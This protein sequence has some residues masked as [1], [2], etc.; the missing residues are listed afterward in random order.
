MT[1]PRPTRFARVAALLLLASP[2]PGA[3]TDTIQFGSATT[4]DTTISAAECGSVSV[5]VPMTWTIRTDGTT[6]SSGGTYEIWAS[7]TAPSASSG[8]SAPLYCP[9][10][11]STSSG[12]TTGEV[13]TLNATTETVASQDELLRAMVLAA[14]YDC[15][16]SSDT[17]IVYVC[18]HWKDSSGN[19]HGSATGQLEI[20]VLAPPAPA[21][22]SVTPGET[23]LYAGWSAGTGSGAPV[24]Y[25]RIHAVPEGASDGPYSGEITGT[26]GT[27]SGLETGKAYQVTVIAYSNPGENPSA[28]SNAVLGTPVPVTDFWEA[29]QAQAGREGGGCASGENGE[30]LALAGVVLA[31][32]VRRRRS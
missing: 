2:I 5:T 26:S 21:L 16:A 6:F 15:S 32:L 12:I 19:R 23:R 14:G 7:N 29:Y 8:T 22:S 28:E 4:A 3:A 11:D 27:I 24:S 31:L 25:Y 17:Q 13:D 20:Q 1:I 10:A 9:T 30:L 18:V